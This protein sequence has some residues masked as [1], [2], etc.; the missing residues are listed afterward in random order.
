[1]ILKKIL[2]HSVIN[3][4][5]HCE[6]QDKCMYAHSL[7]EQ[8]KEPLRE[9]IY[10]ILNYEDDLEDLDL[11]SKDNKKLF[12]EL[13]KLTRICEPCIKRK[14]TGGYN[15]RNGAMSYEYKICYDDLMYGTC[16]KLVCNGVHLTQKKLI[17]YY[18]KKEEMDEIINNPSYIHKTINKMTLTKNIYESSRDIKQNVDMSITD[19][20]LLSRKNDTSDSDFSD[21]FFNELTEYLNKD[22][23]SIDSC[24]KSIFE[25]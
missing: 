22:T 6:Y 25:C 7:E 12:E 21:G 1:M 10:N 4:N 19:K 24:D 13:I 8:K 2:C 23:D 15:C 20:I 14:C 18:G 9:I 17:P 5:S 3:N 11:T 16:D